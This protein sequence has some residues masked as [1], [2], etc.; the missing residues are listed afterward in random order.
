MS[1]V[2][3]LVAVSMVQAM[4][5]V[6]LAGDNVCDSAVT[7]IDGMM[8]TRDKPV[9]LVSIEQVDQERKDEP[10]LFCRSSIAKIFVQAAV[11]SQ[12]RIEDGEHAG[13]FI[14]IGETDAAR[15]ATLNILDRQWRSALADPRNPW[16]DMFRRLAPVIMSVRDQR[17]VDPESKARLAAR[18]TEITVE[19]VHEPAFGAGISDDIEAGL[20]LLEAT[21]DYAHLGPI[22]R[23]LL[24]TEPV[25]W[26]AMQARIFAS[27]VVMGALGLSGGDPPDLSET[28]TIAVDG[29]P[30]IEVSADE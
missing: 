3:Q 6:T 10:G 30:E 22:W 20:A 16:A 2:R 7:A 24:T 18:F 1:I 9:L 12:V 8:E 27:D 23:K 21:P 19:V 11:W 15:E 13:E 28:A 17:M 26:R 4:R 5:G 29:R 25:E 14:A